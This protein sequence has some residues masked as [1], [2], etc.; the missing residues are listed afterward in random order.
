MGVVCSG[1]KGRSSVLKFNTQLRITTAHLLASSIQLVDRWI[2]S[3]QNPM[4]G[5]S[6]RFQPGASHAPGL[7][8]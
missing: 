4:D 2:P 8:R 7:Q 5:P 6:R 3:E 1:C